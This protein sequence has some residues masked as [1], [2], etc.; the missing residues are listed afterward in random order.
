LLKKI[1]WDL[2]SFS[3]QSVLLIAPGS[4]G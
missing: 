4:L 3:E 2:Y 1:E